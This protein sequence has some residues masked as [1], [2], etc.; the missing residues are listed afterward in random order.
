M[1]F[2]ITILLAIFVLPSPW[3]LVAMLVALVIDLGEVGFGLWYAKKRKAAV[4]VSTLVGRKGVAIGELRPEGQVRVGGEIWKARSATGCDAGASVVVCAVD[5]LRL[6][7]E[8]A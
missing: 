1:L 8:S 3:G 5:G 4:G 6:E 7:V 2:L